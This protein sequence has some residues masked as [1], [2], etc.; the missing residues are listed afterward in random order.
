MTINN[1]AREFINELSFSDNEGFN[2]WS[3]FIHA[4]HESDGFK[5]IIGRFNYWGIKVPKNW[6]GLV[7]DLPTFEYEKII[8]DETKEKAKKRIEKKYGRNVEIGNINNYWKIILYQQ[9]IDF[10]SCDNAINWYCNL[11]KRLYEYSYDHRGQPIEYFKGLI[12]GKYKYATDPR[13]SQKLI[14]LYNDL[15]IEKKL[16]IDT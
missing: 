4:F 3:V 13:Y 9:F 12:T 6:N 16:S 2:R 7:L 10:K 1:K 15:K 8:L 5:S 14:N 11:I